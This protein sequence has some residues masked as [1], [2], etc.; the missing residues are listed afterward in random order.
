MPEHITLPLAQDQAG[1][2]FLIT[3]DSEFG[4]FLTYGEAAAVG[5]NPMNALHGIDPRKGYYI[6]DKHAEALN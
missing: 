4:P 6:I 5:E 3:E 2:F 1:Q